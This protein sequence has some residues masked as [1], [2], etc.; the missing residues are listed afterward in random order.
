MSNLRDRLKLKIK[1]D[2]VKDVNEKKGGD[3]PRILNY[4]DLKLDEKM[5]ILFVPSKEGDFWLK[6]H[7]HGPN[8]GI[9]GME[10]ISCPYKSNGDECP[11]CQRGFDYLELSKEAGGK[12]TKE[13]AAL[14][15]EAKKWFAK[16]YTLTQCI[17]LD[18]P[19]DIRQ[20]KDG[21]QVKLF[22]LPYAVEAQ[23]SED[24]KEGKI[25]PDDLCNVPFVIKKT[26]NKGGQPSY[27]HSYFSR[28]SVTDAELEYFDDLVV[29][30]FSVSDLRDLIP[31]DTTTSKVEEWVAKVDEKLSRNEAAEE[32]KAKEEPVKT[33]SS[34][35]LNRKPAAKKEEEQVIEKAS[36]VINEGNQESP[37]DE[38]PDMKVTKEE[39]KEEVADEPKNAI[40]ALRQRLNRGK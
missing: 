31:E 8:L 24:I 15:A 16:D 19:H 4:F 35:V 20:A 11:A 37:D 21:N 18:S 22:I 1:Q 23:I 25:D 30:P 27:Q 36:E 17:V 10:S 14:L 12:E 9:R 34:A 5:T 7:K 26:E 40:S 28:N 39:V 2:I 3:D 38:L 33:K 6:Y 29:E 32:E 13:G